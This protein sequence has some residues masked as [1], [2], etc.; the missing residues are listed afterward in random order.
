MELE[1]PR[2]VLVRPKMINTHLEFVS[3]QTPLNLCYLATVYSNLLIR[4][5]PMDLYFK[6]RPGAFSGVLR[7]APDLLP[8]GSIRIGQVWLD[9]AP[10]ADYDAADLIVNLPDTQDQH[11]IQVRIVPS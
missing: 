1:L 2:L 7:V 3:A 11:T 10:Y 5:Q 4:K 8:P 6:P 9:G